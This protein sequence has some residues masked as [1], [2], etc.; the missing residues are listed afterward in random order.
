M[1]ILV[2]LLAKFF[3]LVVILIHK[4][5]YFHEIELFFHYNLYHFH[6]DFHYLMCLPAAGIAKERMERWTWNQF[7]TYVK[8]KPGARVQPLQ[9][10]F[11][12]FCT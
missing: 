7:Y 10:K 11:Q 1:L 3:Q 2:V 12:L 8:L 4:H 9:D 6:L 5:V